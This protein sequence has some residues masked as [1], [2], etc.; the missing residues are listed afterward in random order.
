MEDGSLDSS[1][2]TSEWKFDPITHVFSKDGKSQN[3]RSVPDNIRNEL[4]STHNNDYSFDSLGL[5]NLDEDSLKQFE[6]Y[7]DQ[8]LE[9]PHKTYDEIMRLDDGEDIIE[10]LAQYANK[11]TQQNIYTIPNI[12]SNRELKKDPYRLVGK[13]GFKKYKE[14]RNLEQAYLR[15]I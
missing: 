10:S 12:G 15:T 14:L 11:S 7:R 1:N 6:S 13:T 4:V 5:N 8:Y 2:P 9:D 3:I